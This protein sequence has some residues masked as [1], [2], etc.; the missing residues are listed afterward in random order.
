MK[1][2]GKLI[3]VLAI[4]QLAAPLKAGPLIVGMPQ[5]PGNNWLLGPQVCIDG[6][7]PIIG[8]PNTL[9]TVIPA[10]RL[11]GERP[12]YIRTNGAGV[13]TG[14][15]RLCRQ[16]RDLLNGNINF[17]YYRGDVDN[18]QGQAVLR[19]VMQLLPYW[20]NGPMAAPTYLINRGQPVR[21]D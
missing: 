17:L 2:L 10:P 13:A 19:R 16:E 15:A 4:T 14:T 20:L 7:L 12:A 11:I 3:L 6:T 8:L 18:M 1:L 21:L 5:M 9:Y